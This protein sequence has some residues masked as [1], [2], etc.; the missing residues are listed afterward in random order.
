MISLVHRASVCENCWNISLVFFR[1]YIEKYKVWCIHC[2]KTTNWC[3]TEEDAI[4][5]WKNREE[6]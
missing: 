4:K 3:D 5:E 6:V 1:E 2:H